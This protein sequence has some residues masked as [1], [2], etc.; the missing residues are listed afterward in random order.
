M[1]NLNPDQISLVIAIMGKVFAQHYLTKEYFGEFLNWEYETYRIFTNGY[2]AIFALALKKVFPQSNF[3]LYKNKEG[4]K[5][6]LLKIN[7]YFYDISGFVPNS[8]LFDGQ[9]EE[10]TDILEAPSIVP[11]DY[12]SNQHNDYYEKMINIMSTAGLDYIAKR[13]WSKIKKI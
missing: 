13:N 2:C 1:E 8:F 7:E 6:I 10:M 12:L 9:L 5:H 3:Y 11:E 4:A